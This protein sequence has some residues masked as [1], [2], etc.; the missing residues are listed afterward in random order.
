MV[1]RDY[2]EVRRLVAT[3]A[4]VVCVADVV[5]ADALMAAPCVGLI[6]AG[7]HLACSPSGICLPS[8]SSSC[9]FPPSCARVGGGGKRG[10]DF[11]AR[12]A[13]TRFIHRSPDRVDPEPPTV[14]YLMGSA[15]P[16]LTVA[17]SSSTTRP[18]L[19]MHARSA[20]TGGIARRPPERP[21][22]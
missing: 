11:G 13:L 1:P 14:Q 10:E 15:A 22:P 2:G 5:G 7:L 16:H 20:N 4:T 8:L 3:V 17:P 6:A 19:R 18:F 21:V 12:R 9:C